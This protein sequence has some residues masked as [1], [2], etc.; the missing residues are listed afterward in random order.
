MEDTRADPRDRR[1]AAVVQLVGAI[2]R[3]QFG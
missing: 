2:D 1:G 3:E